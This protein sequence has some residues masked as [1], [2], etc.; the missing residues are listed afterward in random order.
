MGF[1]SLGEIGSWLRGLGSVLTCE[2]PYQTGFYALARARGVK[3]INQ[4]NPE[5]FDGW[6]GSDQ[7]PDVILLPSRWLESDIRQAF[8][9][10]AD[11]IYL[12]PPVDPSEF[13]EVRELNFGRAG[14]RHI[15]HPIGRPAAEDRAG[16]RLLLQS[17]QHCQSDFTLEIISQF[18]LPGE[19]TA[20]ADARVTFSVGNRARRVD[21]F[22]EADGVIHPRRYGGLNMMGIEALMSGLPVIMPNASPN[23]DVLPERWLV[24]GIMTGTFMTRR[25]IPLFDASS[26]A[27]AERIDWLCNLSDDQL[28]AEKRQAFQ[29]GTDNYSPE[30]LRPQYEAVL[31]S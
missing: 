21:L 27:L 2:L 11:I 9:N 17:I 8:G 26:S 29:L 5:F 24:E 28:L 13:A 20:G 6:L 3:I 4:I 23:N 15:V 25:P 1:P 16:T 18:P 14:R 19:L 22:R 31:G 30:V 7:I 10:R 12:P